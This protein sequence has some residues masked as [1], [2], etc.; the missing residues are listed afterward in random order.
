MAQ[1]PTTKSHSCSF[2]ICHPHPWVSTTGSV[3]QTR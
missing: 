3:R 2:F 1:Q